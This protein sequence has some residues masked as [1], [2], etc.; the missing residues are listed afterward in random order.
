MHR[1]SLKLV[2]AMW[3][4]IRATA[5]AEPQEASVALSSAEFP[6]S[7]SPQDSPPC[8]ELRTEILRQAMS[9]GG[10]EER[11]EQEALVRL[12][13]I[14]EGVP[15]A[16]PGETCAATIL[17]ELSLAPVCGSAAE[18]ATSA[19][20]LDGWLAPM[21][22]AET[23]KGPGSCVTA[24]VAGLTS[25]PVVDAR[26]L[27][28]VESWA[29]QQRDPLRR[30]GGLVVLGALARQ[31]RPEDPK[32]AARVDATLERE[33]RR[34]AASQ[35]EHLQRIEAAGNAGCRSCEVALRLETRARSSEVRRTAIGAL[36]FVPTAG[37]TR[38]MCEGVEG[39]SD[40][41]VREQAAWALGWERTEETERVNCLVRAA[42]RDAS[43]HVRMTAVQA[44]AAQMKEV[45][46]ARSA[47]LA[48]TAPEYGDD[49][50]RAFA[51]RLVSSLPPQ[52]FDEVH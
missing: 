14:A 45:P 37:A 49:A 52:T 22:T 30:S 12:V 6:G 35:T 18:L 7:P 26:L 29:L 27:G 16:R 32:A 38:T 51:T 13:R 46:L 23:L 4:A 42:A 25:A 47:M 40:P 31:A 9:P 50:V 44:L 11:D 5:F 34:P 19:A 10:S 3:L 33:L 36:R 48:L 41:K 43:A 2:A 24:I 21:L 39:D 17:G 1:H 20:A 28:L 15:G 8:E